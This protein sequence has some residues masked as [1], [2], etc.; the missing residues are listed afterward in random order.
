MRPRLRS[1]R[2]G[3]VSAYAL[4]ALQDRGDF[5]V[6]PASPVYEGMVVGEHCKSGD[7]AVNATREKKLTN[8]RASGSDR[9]LK[10]AP[11]R[12]FG[13]EDALEYIEED[14]LVEVTP[15]SIRIRKRVLDA[16]ARK[17]LEKAAESSPQ[18]T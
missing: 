3:Q 14:E 16:T 18:P 2:S 17:R 10:V 4:D 5:F 15:L 1:V 9:A 8:M 11:P 6:K 12:E 7:I 13:L